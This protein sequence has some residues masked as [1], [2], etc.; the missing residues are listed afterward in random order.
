MRH[1]FIS[2]SPFSSRWL[3]VFIYLFYKKERRFGVISFYFF[4]GLFFVILWFGI[5]GGVFF[6][7][8][9]LYQTQ[10]STLWAFLILLSSYH[11]LA[12]FLLFVYVG[13]GVYLFTWSLFS[14]GRLGGIQTRHPA[15]PFWMVFF[16]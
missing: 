3:G 10:G 11:T 2:S 7:F 5:C 14:D 9:F 4:M 1:L 12:V 16:C 13:L 8:L 15:A 6:S